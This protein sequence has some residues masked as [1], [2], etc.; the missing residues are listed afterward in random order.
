MSVRQGVVDDTVADE[1][2][3]VC[4]TI[5]LFLYDM[6]SSHLPGG[7]VKT[8]TSQRFTIPV[9]D[10]LTNLPSCKSVQT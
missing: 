6:F 10:I 2:Q 7:T 1:I 4:L 3:D 5:V 8:F 9:L